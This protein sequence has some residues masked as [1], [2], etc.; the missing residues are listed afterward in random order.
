MP[1]SPPHP[2]TEDTVV[3]PDRGSSN[4]TPRWVKVSATVALVLVVVVVVMLLMGA[5]GGHGPGRH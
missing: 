1:E 5:P 4:G 2:D 3:G